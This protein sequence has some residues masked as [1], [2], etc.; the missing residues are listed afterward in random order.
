[1]NVHDHW[2]SLWSPYQP[3]VWPPVSNASMNHASNSTSQKLQLSNKA[4]L[5]TL[6]SLR[7]NANKTWRTWDIYRDYIQ[8]ILKK[9]ISILSS[10]YLIKWEQKV[11]SELIKFYHRLDKIQMISEEYIR[12]GGSIHRAVKNG[13]DKFSVGNFYRVYYLGTGIYTVSTCSN[14]NILVFLVYFR[15]T[16]SFE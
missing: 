4:F 10:A 5:I 6:L 9:S 14:S 11:S 7:Q 1:M 12:L 8:N 13:M 16:G 2:E 3:L 15:N